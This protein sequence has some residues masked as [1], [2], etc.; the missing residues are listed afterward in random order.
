MVWTERS[1][2]DSSKIGAAVVWWKEAHPR[3]EW[4]GQ[5]GRRYCPRPVNAGWTGRRYHLSDNKEVFDAEAFALYQAL[6]ILDARNGKGAKC[7]VFS[8]ST[9]ALTSNV[10][11]NRPGPGFRRGYRR[12]D[13]TTDDPRILS[14]PTLGSGPQGSRGQRNGGRLRQGGGRGRQRLGG[15]TA[16]TPGVDIP[17]HQSDNRGQDP[18][19]K[20]LD[21]E[22]YQLTTPAT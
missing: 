20:G 4:T 13:K 5:S 11:P 1:R 16:P 12:G 7:T 2:L 21:L 18:R 10:R 22:Q 8:D 14:L 3:P 19:Y 6:K 9:A 17:P 15:S